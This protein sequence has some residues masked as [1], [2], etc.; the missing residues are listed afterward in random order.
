L[1]GF[2]T[3]LSSYWNGKKTGLGHVITS[4]FCPM[5]AMCCPAWK[6]ENLQCC[7]VVHEEREEY[8]MSMQGKEKM[9]GAF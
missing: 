6:Q 9:Q 2:P 5:A 7:T 8:K 4:E 3:L 1:S